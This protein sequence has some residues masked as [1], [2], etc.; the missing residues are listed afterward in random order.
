MQPITDPRRA[1]NRSRSRSPGRGADDETPY[2]GGGEGTYGMYTPDS[3]MNG[4]PPG[5]E[6][7]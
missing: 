2:G 4:T 3:K 7:A 6:L 1:R 5:D